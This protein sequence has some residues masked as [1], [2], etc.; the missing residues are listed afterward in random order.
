MDEATAFAAGHRPC[1]YCQ[2]TR[3]IEFKDAWVRA[4]V[5]EELHVKTSM[6]DVDKVIHAERE[7]S[8]G[9]KVIF[10]ATPLELPP[11]SMFEHENTAFLV[12][13]C[14]YLPWSFDGYGVPLYIDP[15]AVVKVL[16][17][18]SIVRAFAEGFMPRVHPSATTTASL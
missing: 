16:T 12:A 17:P 1:A 9:G 13:T 7:I 6:P 11:G 8:R 14:G 3:H 2:R 5:A 15:G 18:R 10:E 4:N